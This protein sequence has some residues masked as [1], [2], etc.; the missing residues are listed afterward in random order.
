MRSFV[1]SYACRS[2]VHCVACRDPGT[3]GQ[4]FRT[5]LG[6][7]YTLPADAPDGLFSCPNGITAAA[8]QAAKPAA[9]IDL[10]E[11]AMAERLSVCETCEHSRALA[12]DAPG[13]ALVTCQGCRRRGSPSARRFAELLKSGAPCPHP[14]GNRWLG[15]TARACAAN[16]H[17]SI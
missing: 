2:R 1:D 14:G 17:A 16:R 15:C 7:A 8:A 3:G 6:T 12:D 10:D 13:C 11:P 9:S 4:A 5:S